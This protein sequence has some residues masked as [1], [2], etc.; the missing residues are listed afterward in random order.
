MNKQHLNNDKKLINDSLI[1]RD[2]TWNK[3]WNILSSKQ[4]FVG[5]WIKTKEEIKNELP[6]IIWDANIIPWEKLEINHEDFYEPYITYFLMHSYEEIKKTKSIKKDI[7]EYI[8]SHTYC[9]ELFQAFI[10][11]YLEY[12]K[13]EKD[14][15]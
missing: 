3:L 12:T 7:K 10:I 13:K 1:L 4:S 8:D 5:M 14:I 6:R 11:S 2:M 15:E 9:D